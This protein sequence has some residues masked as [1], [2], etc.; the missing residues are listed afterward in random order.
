[1][2]AIDLKIAIKSLSRHKGYSP[3]NILGLAIGL[4][5]FFVVALFVKM[6]TTS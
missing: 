4:A 3:L 5:A 2:I 6:E 1:M